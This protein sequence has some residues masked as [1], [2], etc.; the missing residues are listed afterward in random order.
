MKHLST[1]LAFLPL[2]LAAQTTW[3][4]EAG[5]NMSGG[6]DPYYAPQDITIA[7]GDIVH[8]DA[9]SGTHNVN[10]SLTLYPA[11]PVGFN[12]GSPTANLDFSFTFT[13]P[14]F[15]EYRCTMSGHG[16]TQFGSITVES[17]Q[18]VS[19]STELGRIDLF[20]VPANDQLT[21]ELD[22]NTLSLVE[23]LSVDGRVMRTL[24]FDRMQ[25][26]VIGLEGMATG[27]YFLRFTDMQ[28]RRT[29]RPFLKA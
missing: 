20:P 8:W 21:V 7:V 23:V 28:G 29:V 15:Y 2:T 19:E 14:G 3:E 16:A 4:V 17:A 1:F 5:G 25:R 6:P 18:N 9:V 22:N 24:P 11:N 27:R 12:S 26:V 10:G 13:V